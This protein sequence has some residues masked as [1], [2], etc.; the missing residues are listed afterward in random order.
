V[1]SGGEIRRSAEAGKSR[2]AERV[3]NAI[4]MDEYRVITVCPF[5]KPVIGALKSL[6]TLDRGVIVDIHGEEVLLCAFTGG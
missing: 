3:V 2:K 5:E 1:S 6:I 4:G